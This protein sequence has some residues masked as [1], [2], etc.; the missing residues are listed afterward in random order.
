[1]RKALLA[2]LG[3]GAVGGLAYA[4]TRKKK[5]PKAPVILVDA[6]GEALLQLSGARRLTDAELG[7]SI[8]EIGGLKG[9]IVVIRSGLKPWNGGNQST[10]QEVIDGWRASVG[11]FLE[12]GVRGVVYVPAILPWTPA[13][14]RVDSDLSAS[15]LRRVTQMVDTWAKQH[16]ATAPEAD[17]LFRAVVNVDALK[18]EDGLID[19]RYGDPIHGLNAAGVAALTA[20]I[21]AA[22]TLAQGA[23]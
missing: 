18:A 11:E 9:A 17:P 20:Q 3:I 6:E 21:Q 5:T 16:T 1:M 7:E 10:A 12:Q 19:A 22:I 4:V 2:L 15:A 13:I 14:E 23:A 8:D